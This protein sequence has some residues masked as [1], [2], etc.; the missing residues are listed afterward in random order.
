MEGEML[1]HLADLQEK[2]IEQYQP[3][4]RHE[5]LQEVLQQ[6]AQEIR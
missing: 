3:E 4:T 6:I 1:E 5:G 2:H